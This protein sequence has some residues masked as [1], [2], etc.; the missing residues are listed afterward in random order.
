MIRILFIG[1]LFVGLSSCQVKQNPSPEKG[2]AKQDTVPESVQAQF[3]FPAIPSTLTE[4]EAR[5]S[6]LLTH[7]WEQFDYADTTLV[8]N[9]DVTEQGF[10]NFREPGELV[11]GFRRERTCTQSID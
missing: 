4:P 2:V 11:C 3:P 6:Y 10:V 7:Y 9:R 1:L 8:N 5:K